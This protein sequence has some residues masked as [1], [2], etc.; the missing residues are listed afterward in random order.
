MLIKHAILDIIKK[1]C[2]KEGEKESER[3]CFV[4]GDVLSK[5]VL[6]EYP[7]TELCGACLD[8]ELKKGD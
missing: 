5:K 3:K 6:R 8:L 7:D 4:C 2:E 1:A